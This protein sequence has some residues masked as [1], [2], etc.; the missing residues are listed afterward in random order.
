M[1]SPRAFSTFKNINWHVYKKV[2]LSAFLLPLFPHF[3]LVVSYHLSPHL[4][5]LPPLPSSFSLSHF[6]STQPN[7]IQTSLSLSLSLIF[8][9]AQKLPPL[10]LPPFHYPVCLNPFLSLENF[11]LRMGLLS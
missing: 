8:L 11:I 6:P 10:S 2:S 9:F 1:G 7:S 3:F 4:S 5:S